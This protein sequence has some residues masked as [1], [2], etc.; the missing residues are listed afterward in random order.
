MASF[1][2]LDALKVFHDVTITSLQNFPHDFS[3]RQ[4][5]VLM[6]VYLYPQPHTVRSLSQVLGVSKPAVCRALDT[7]ARYQLIKRKRDAEDRRN[8][9]IHR[10]VRGSVL[11]SEYAE[12]ILKAMPG[13]QPAPQSA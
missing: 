2:N 7:L 1:S 5:G 6:H 8:V 12:I 10:T 11:L 9:F 3:A 4:M 13:K